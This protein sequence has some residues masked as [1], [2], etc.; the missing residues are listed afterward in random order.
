MTEQS[1][2]P[3]I[4]LAGPPGAGK[5]TLGSA[6]CEELALRFLDLAA[7]AG[8]SAD[9]EAQK[10]TLERVI[11]QRTADVAEADSPLREDLPAVPEVAGGAEVRVRFPPSPAANGC[12][13][14]QQ[15]SRLC[16]NW[17]CLR[18]KPGKES[19]ALVRP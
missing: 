3:M 17:S 11:S 16:R 5:T 10:K 9:V 15:A 18:T 12:C 6:G 19:N 14:A 1:T 4:F 8:A 2:A 13:C 7:E